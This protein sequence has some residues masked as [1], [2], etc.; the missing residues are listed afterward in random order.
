MSNVVV[1]G[2]DGSASSLAAVEEAARE[3]LWRDAELRIV[4]GLALPVM[5]MHVPMDPSPLG[6]PEDSLR[7][8]AERLVREAAE[9]ARRVA[10]PVRVS[11]AVL[12]G[13]ALTA[14]E[15]QSRTA[16]LVVVGSRGMGGFIGMLLGS[17]AVFLTA[18]GQCPV[19][20]VREQPDTSGPVLLGVDGSTAGAKA[21][22]FA[23]A[24]AA[25]RRAEIIALH[26]HRNRP[27]ATDESVDLTKVLAGH[28]ERHPDVA[29]S[30]AVVD[31]GPR[32]ALIEASKTAQLTVVG[33]RGRGGFTGLLLGSV[34]QALLHHAH[35]PV[36]VVRGKG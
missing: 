35:S 8:V 17:T 24:E 5:P 1:A 25:L 23:F 36:A 18:H 29:V 6:P 4:H 27:G 34:S 21:L 2:V 30:Q 22:E 9:R 12:N 13:D 16:D 33:A 11:Q 26:A 19:M 32:E 15:L 7:K 10:P 31:D 20:V 28:Q 14:L 3:A